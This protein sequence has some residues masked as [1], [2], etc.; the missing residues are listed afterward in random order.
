[1]RE[2]TIYV[3]GACSGNPGPGGYA[4]ILVAPNGA[5][6]E[7]SGGFRLTTNSRMEIMAVIQ[8][9]SALKEPCHVTLY[10]DSQYV[11]NAIESGWLRMWQ[12]N[13][14][15]KSG[16]GPVENVDL[17]RQLVPLLETHRVT[18]VWL[19]GHNG[20]P[21]NERCDQLAEKACRMPNLP[22]DEGYEVRRRAALR[23]Y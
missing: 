11:V 14:W 5:C 1:M 16:K 9:L 8:A 21:L 18:F 20:H 10:S 13:G 7:I 23:L 15:R 19:R 2:V 12:A 4:A 3:D 17:W 22:P 6:R